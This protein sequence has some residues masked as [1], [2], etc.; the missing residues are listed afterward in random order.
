MKK[1]LIASLSIIAVFAFAIA[2]YALTQNTSPT[3][4]P[5]CCKSTDSCPIKANTAKVGEHAKSDCCNDGCNCCKGG[6]CP[7]KKGEKATKASS[8]GEA[9]AEKKCCNTC[10]CCASKKAATDA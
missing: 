3:T 5:S 4:P 10:D 9:E 2:A 6:S 7:M 1:K 8:A